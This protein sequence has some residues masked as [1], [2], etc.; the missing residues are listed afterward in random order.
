MWA[1][2]HAWSPSYWVPCRWI[3]CSRLFNV[4]ISLCGCKCCKL[5]G[6]NAIVGGSL[7]QAQ[8]ALSSQDGDLRANTGW[9]LPHTGLAHVEAYCLW[10]A[11]ASRRPCMAVLRDLWPSYRPHSGGEA[12]VGRVSFSVLLQKRAGRTKEQGENITGWSTI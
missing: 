8:P 10:K 2:G 5:T 7:L 3:Y 1:Y 12:G 4:M 6:A 9:L 11:T